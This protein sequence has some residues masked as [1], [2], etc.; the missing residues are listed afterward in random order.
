M[1]NMNMPELKSPLT[2]TD[3]ASSA[4]EPGPDIKQLPVGSSIA[5]PLNFIPKGGRR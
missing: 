1:A 5:D 3:R 4:N 2:V